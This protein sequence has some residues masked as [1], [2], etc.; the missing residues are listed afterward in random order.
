MADKFCAEIV[1]RSEIDSSGPGLEIALSDLAGRC[2][3]LRLG[4]DAITA[5]KEILSEFSASSAASS[6]HLTKIPN[7]YAVG[8]GRYEPFVLLRFEDDA[9]YGLSP[10]QAANLAEALLDEAEAASMVQYAMRQ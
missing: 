9:A 4:A 2:E 6:Q 8:H 5:L 10:V 3:T 7:R 1:T